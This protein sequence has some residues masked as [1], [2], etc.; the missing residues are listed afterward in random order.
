[1]RERKKGDERELLSV[2]GENTDGTR[3]GKTHL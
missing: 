1:M 2:L 3:T